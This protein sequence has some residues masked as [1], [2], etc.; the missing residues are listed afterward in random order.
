[1]ADETKKESKN[2]EE[3]EDI[4]PMYANNI[5]FEMSAWDLRIFFGQ[6][7]PGG[8]AEVEYHTDVAIPWAQAKLMHL[9]LG[10]NIMLYE[11]QNGRIPIPKSVLPAP[12][13][14]PPE[15]TDTSSPESIETFQQVQR[16]IAEFRDGEQG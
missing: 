4:V 13:A 1:M 8:E 12:L 14:S 9:Y 3:Y 7:V 6:L 16:K 5:R 2:E 11:R 15:D 10:I